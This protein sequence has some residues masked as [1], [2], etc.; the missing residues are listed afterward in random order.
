MNKLCCVLNPSIICEGCGRYWCGT[1]NS[2]Q[3]NEW[4]DQKKHPLKNYTE[5]WTCVA[6][7]KMVNTTKDVLEEPVRLRVI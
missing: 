1:C 4:L 6:S 5:G 2:L 7:G 3:N